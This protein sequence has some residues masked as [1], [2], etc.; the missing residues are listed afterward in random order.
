MKNVGIVQGS[1]TQAIPLVVGKDTVYVHKNIQPVIE[2]GKPV[3]NL[4][5]YHETQYTL[6]E[7]IQ[8]FSD[9]MNI[10]LADSD[11]FNIDQELRLALIE[12]ELGVK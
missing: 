9:H 1:A 3:D 12:L 2:D 5:S 8:M 4:F 11:A 10:A 6:N 7:Y